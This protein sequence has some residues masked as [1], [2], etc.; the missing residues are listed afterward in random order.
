LYN[1]DQS[2][3]PTLL[4]MFLRR[5]TPSRSWSWYLR[6]KTCKKLNSYRRMTT[7]TTIMRRRKKKRATRLKAKIMKITLL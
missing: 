1:L 6:E 2:Y 3:N 7:M 5:R 4:S